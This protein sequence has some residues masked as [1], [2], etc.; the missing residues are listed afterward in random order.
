MSNSWPSGSAGVLGKPQQDCHKQLDAIPA[1]EIEISVT[2]TLSLAPE[3]PGK[4]ENEDD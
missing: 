2:T 3:N 4:E 1:Q